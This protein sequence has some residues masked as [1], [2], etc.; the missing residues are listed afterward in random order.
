MAVES[1]GRG[2]LTRR[3]PLQRMT[4]RDCIRNSR[5]VPSIQ[6]LR[7]NIFVDKNHRSTRFDCSGSN[8]DT[9][10]VLAAVVI[11]VI[12]VIHRPI[13]ILVLSVGDGLSVL[14]SIPIMYDG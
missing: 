13:T 9:T 12:D 1:S 11:D 2:S 3:D 5:R 6:L 8:I 4:Y 7:T 10:N 14:N